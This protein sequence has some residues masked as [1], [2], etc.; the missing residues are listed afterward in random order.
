M[1]L[2]TLEEHNIERERLY[3]FIYE[4]PQPN[5]IACPK[6]GKE[7]MDSDALSLTSMPPKRNI[8]CS[9]SNCDFTGYRVD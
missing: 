6:C 7:L 2:K 1:P 8:H 9:S 3:R 4:Y 5:G